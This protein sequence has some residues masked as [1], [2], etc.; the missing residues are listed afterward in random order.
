MLTE[1]NASGAV[2]NLFISINITIVNFN[3]YFFLQRTL[4]YLLPQY[5]NF[6]LLKNL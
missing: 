4:L 3:I 5:G 1:V 6:A 2:L